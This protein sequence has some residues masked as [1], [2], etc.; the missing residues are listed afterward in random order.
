MPNTVPMLLCAVSDLLNERRPIPAFSKASSAG[1][2]SVADVCK[3][4][5]SSLLDCSALSESLGSVAEEDGEAVPDV[6]L[7]SGPKTFAF[8]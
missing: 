8:S 5:P 2:G 4:S 1:T 6:S 7:L 3:G